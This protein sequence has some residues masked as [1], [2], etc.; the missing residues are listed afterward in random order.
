MRRRMNSAIKYLICL[1]WIFCC[2]GL[3]GCQLLQS[4]A[5]STDGAAIKSL[6]FEKESLEYT[7]AVGSDA[8]H[9]V[10]DVAYN[11]G[12]IL[13]STAD[14]F[15]F[16]NP[17]PVF[18]SLK[19]NTADGLFP[20]EISTEKSGTF[21]YAATLIAP[22]GYYFS[23][24]LNVPLFKVTV[25]I[26]DE[27]EKT[28]LTDVIEQNQFIFRYGMPVRQ[29]ADLSATLANLYFVCWDDKAQREVYLDASWDLSDVNLN[30]PGTYK[31]HVSFSITDQNGCR[32]LYQLSEDFPS[33]VTV[34]VVDPK[35]L[36]IY[37]TSYFLTNSEGYIFCDIYQP[38]DITTE[39]ECY[40]YISKT[41]LSEKELGAVTF[42]K[43][44]DATYFEYVDLSSCVF[45]TYEADTY[46]YFYLKNGELYSNYLC[47]Y[48]DEN[49]LNT[50]IYDGNRDGGG[51]NTKLPDV[52]QSNESITRVED[53]GSKEVGS[54]KNNNSSVRLKEKKDSSKNNKKDEKENKEDDE[55]VSSQSDSSG[56]Q[57]TANNNTKK[58]GQHNRSDKAGAKSSNTQNSEADSSSGSEKDTTGELTISAQRV[59]SLSELAEPLVVTKDNITAILDS[60][61]LQAL[62]L[63]ED[64]S[65]SIQISMSKDNIL[66]LT[67]LINGVVVEKFPAIKVNVSFDDAHYEGGFTVKDS[68]GNILDNVT[69]VNEVLSFET[70]IG[71]DF[72]IENNAEIVVGV[73]SPK[74]PTNTKMPIYPYLIVGSVVILGVGGVVYYRRK[75]RSM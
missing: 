45:N 25:N 9:I 23:D 48:Y 13:G 69:Y 39:A 30:S 40:Y 49:D 70:T 12:Y 24:A 20:S 58:A 35:A 5:Q 60:E 2:N 36:E 43:T 52:N 62:N 32:D 16:R 10:E 66:T 44:T 37:M 65:L 63:K 73:S 22:E 50:Y 46:Y 28:I 41:A 54:T 34:Y 74:P 14:T 1:V 31:A 17:A 57:N 67:V 21:V 68:N 61:G 64:D 72:A 56:K 47:V 38:A 59:R 29:G 71:G 8:S 7:V 51:E 6:H 75:R 55:A 4:N 3:L 33:E 27:I 18:L 11:S 53:S 26:I 15:T 19:W 42:N